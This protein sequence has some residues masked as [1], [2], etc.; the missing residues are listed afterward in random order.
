MYAVVEIAGSQFKV[1]KNTEFNVNRIDAKAGKEFKVKNI[2]LYSDAKHIEVGKPYL[3]NVEV[4][5]D[6]IEEL[7]GKKL[8]AYKYKKRKKQRRKKG[9]RQEL[10]K[11]KV[12]EIKLKI[13]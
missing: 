4:I 11:L 12:K 7:R 13:K 6:V 10:T 1:E 5:C 3:K 2:L 8:I 9:H